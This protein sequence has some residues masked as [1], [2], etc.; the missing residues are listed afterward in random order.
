[1]IRCDQI[2]FLPNITFTIGG[3]KFTIQADEYVIQGLR[4][5][6]YCLSAF[7]PHGLSNAQHYSV[8]VVEMCNFLFRDESI[9]V[10]ANI[11]GQIF[12]NL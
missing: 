1:M 8:V 12:G 3:R 11:S 10:W 7:R 9:C 6:Q 4:F 5:D 2:P